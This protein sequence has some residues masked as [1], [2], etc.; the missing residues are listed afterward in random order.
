MPAPGV[1]PV[2]DEFYVGSRFY[3]ELKKVSIEGITEISGL[4]LEIDV[5]DVNQ[6]SATG[7]LSK[8]RP[9]GAKFGDI[10][11]KR[12]MSTDKSWYQWAK[13]IRDRKPDFRADGA[14]TLYSFDNK[15]VGRWT[16]TNAWPSKWSASDLDVGSDDPMT[17]ELT[18]TIELLTRDK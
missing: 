1:G 5:V 2:K 18:L 11:L 14:V 17:E 10:T 16:F 9:A 4:A 7:M 8:K 12:P 15:E 3:I 13:D 6:Q